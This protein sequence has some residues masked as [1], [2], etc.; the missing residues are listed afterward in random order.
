[1]DE[2]ANGRRSERMNGGSTKAWT[3][4]VANGRTD[5]RN[6]VNILKYFK[7]LNILILKSLAS[8]KGR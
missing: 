7:I 5:E 1:M 4:E 3:D 2:R 6:K 8:Y